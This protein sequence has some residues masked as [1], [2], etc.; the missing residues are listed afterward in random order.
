M[1]APCGC[2]SAVLPG[3]HHRHMILLVRAIW[4]AI[5]GTTEN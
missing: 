2:L 1:S 5:A 4:R 3:L